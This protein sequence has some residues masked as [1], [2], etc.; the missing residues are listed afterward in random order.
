MKTKTPSSAA[1]ERLA[2]TQL[3]F[4]AHLRHPEA[5][6][7]PEGVEERRL[8]VYRGLFYRN[9]HGFISNN[10]PVLRRLYS[11]ADWDAMVRDFYH[12][13]RSATPLF[14]EIPR[15][16]LKYLQEER[17]PTPDDPPFLLELAHYE[18]IELAVSLDEGEIETVPAEAGGDLLTGIPVLSPV[19]RLLSYRFPV[20]RI[21][22]DYQ[23]REAPPDPTW[24]LVYRNRLDQV[25]FMQLN[26]VSALLLQT[27]QENP[28]QTGLSILEG[29]AGQ[30]GSSDTRNVIEHGRQLMEDLQQ[31]DVILG[32]RP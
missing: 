14:P 5:H 27:M 18:W 22:P 23:P 6:P 10:F 17:A 30:L 1:P 25:R 9:I 20:H 13:H 8:E 3:A 32:T 2:Q 28:D 24:L 29:I 15:E 21:R 19:S 31:R 11:P 16:F 4:A 12:R 26:P 7:A